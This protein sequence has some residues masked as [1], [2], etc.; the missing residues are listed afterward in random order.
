MWAEI[1][2]PPICFP[3][4]NMSAVPE[5][6]ARPFWKPESWSFDI[7]HMVQYNLQIYV[8]IRLAHI[9]M[10]RLGHEYG[11]ITKAINKDPASYG[12]SDK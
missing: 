6:F 8:S 12:L 11:I 4:G 9:K 1:G 10:I 2:G 3:Y 5:I 7:M